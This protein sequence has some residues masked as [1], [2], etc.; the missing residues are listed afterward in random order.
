MMILHGVVHLTL[1]H[2]IKS[3]NLMSLGIKKVD[4]GSPYN[5]DW[6][7]ALL[8]HLLLAIIMSSHPQAPLSCRQFVLAT[9]RGVCGIIYTSTYTIIRN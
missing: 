1:I 5:H 9:I 4:I 7:Y 8:L 6:P 2:L 3:Q